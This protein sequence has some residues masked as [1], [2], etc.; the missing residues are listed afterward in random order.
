MRRRIEGLPELR[1][2]MAARYRQLAA[3][4]YEATGEETT[5]WL[6]FAAALERGDEVQLPGWQVAPFVPGARLARHPTV[7]VAPDGSV[8]VPS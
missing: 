7:I 2:E 6:N 5:G 1:A 3:D 8:S 4:W